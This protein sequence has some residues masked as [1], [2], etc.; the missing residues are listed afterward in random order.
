VVELYAEYKAYF[1]EKED[2][3]GL[4]LLN[5]IDLEK[6]QSVL[7][8][9]NYFM[10]AVKDGS[11][12]KKPSL[13]LCVP[14]T[15]FMIRRAA[16]NLTSND[17]TLVKLSEG[18]I[19]GVALKIL[20][21]FKEEHFLACFFN[22]GWFGGFF[23]FNQ[24]LPWDKDFFTNYLASIDYRSADLC[25]KNEELQFIPDFCVVEDGENK[26]VDDA[27]I[28]FFVQSVVSKF[29]ERQPRVPLINDGDGNDDEEDEM[30]GVPEIA[31]QTNNV[32]CRDE[33]GVKQL[34][35]YYKQ[36]EKGYRAGDNPYNKSLQKSYN[37]NPIPFW[38]HRTD[39][40]IEFSKTVIRFIQ[41][42]PGSVPSERCFSDLNYLYSKRRSQLESDTVDAYLIGSS[43]IKAKRKLR[44]RQAL[45]KFRYI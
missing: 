21:V 34:V 45:K 14:N 7:S 35:E 15:S 36:M 38:T 32:N 2:N 23:N 10:V 33:E 37:D 27:C 4:Q 5:E 3:D 13:H 44:Q 20:R 16:G 17:N 24:I 8:L 30:W 12:Q 25:I 43:A 1:E 28:D 31:P 6:C 11:K 40:P 18:I 29:P 9:F 19:L 41:I 39:F 42:R 26:N 22:P